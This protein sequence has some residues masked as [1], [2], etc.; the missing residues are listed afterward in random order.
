MQ[1]D[2]IYTDGGVISKNP[3]PI[4]GTWAWCWVRKG[5]CVYY[6]SGVILAH[7]YRTISN[8]FTEL[9]AAVKA[10]ES[11]PRDWNGVL[12]TDSAVTKARMTTGTR[13]E[14]VP[15]EL[16]LNVLKLRRGR[17][18]T[19]QLVAGHPTKKHLREGHKNGAPVSKH[20]VFCDYLCGSRA[21]EVIS[22]RGRL[23]LTE[24]RLTR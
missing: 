12:Y 10:I 23:R 20:N 1:P 8:N 19:V 16:R 15:N 4:G 14:G 24:K 9:V 3:S 2:E 21:R 22:E 6:K 18:W 5:K 17:K 13:F 7:E 11:V